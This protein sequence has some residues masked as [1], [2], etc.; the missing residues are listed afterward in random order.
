MFD[1]DKEIGTVITSLFTMGEPFILFGA[2]I[3]RE[4]YPTDIGPAVQSELRVAKRENPTETFVVT[5]L[6]SSIATKVRE[7]EAGD[8]P[9]IVCLQ[10]VDSKKYPGRQALVLQ[11][12]KPWDPSE[13]GRQPSLDEAVTSG[14]VPTAPVADDDIPF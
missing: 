2:R 7:A 1:K 3:K 10:R 14:Q 13:N 11:F 12:L 9:A 6:A 8:F 5:T 4:D